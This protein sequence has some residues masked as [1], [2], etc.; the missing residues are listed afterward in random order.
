[1][2][3][4]QWSQMIRISF[5]SHWKYAH[6]TKAHTFSSSPFVPQGFGRTG[7]RNMLNNS[8]E[9]KIAYDRLRQAEQSRQVK[10]MKV[11]S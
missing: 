7:M 3:P 8:N 5:S 1:M 4:L 11:P 6:Q 2:G 9:M 10:M